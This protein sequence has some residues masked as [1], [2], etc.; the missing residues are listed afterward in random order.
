MQKMTSEKLFSKKWFVAYIFI[1]SGSFIMAVGFVLFISP[2]KLAPGGV[3]GISITLHYVY[4]MY[5][6]TLMNLLGAWIPY[7]LNISIVAICMDIPLCLLGI[8][9]L[10]PIFGIKTVVGFSLL[11]LFTFILENT[12]GYNP[13]VDDAMLSAIFGGV[14][15]GFGVGFIFK[16]KGTSGGTDIIA[17]IFSKNFHMPIGTMLII[18]D[19]IIVLLALVA[20]KDWK[21]PLYSWIV[22]YIAGQVINATMYGFRH[23]KTM[24]IVSE[25]YEEIAKFIIDLDRGGTVLYGEGMYTHKSK[26]IIYT[27]VNVREVNL[28]YEYIRDIDPEAFV[29]VV[30]A[31][32]VVGEGR[33]F[34]SIYES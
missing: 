12:W 9:V 18:V 28:I 31:N 5:H 34:K 11:A 27:N 32:E 33:G 23:I 4:E 15:I 13:L 16:A 7:N 1:L 21:I 10:G 2:Y 20:F 29:T 17:M 14:L 22:I 30:N 19:S 26:K 8:R 25:K 6:S 3:Y 24:F